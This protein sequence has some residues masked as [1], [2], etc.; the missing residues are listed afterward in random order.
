MIATVTTTEK[1]GRERT[2]RKGRMEGS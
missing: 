1:Q 2:R